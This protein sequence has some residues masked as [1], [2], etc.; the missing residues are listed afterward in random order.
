MAQCDLLITD[1]SSIYLDYLLLDRP[2]VFFAYDLEHY[3]ERDRA[4]YFTYESMTPGAR[5]DTQ[6]KLENVLTAILSSGCR[7][8][9]A[10]Q[11]NGVRQFTHDNLGPGSVARLMNKLE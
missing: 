3:V 4:L 7:D 6:V 11:R 2:I 10:E 8:E 5:C 9:Y 1:Y